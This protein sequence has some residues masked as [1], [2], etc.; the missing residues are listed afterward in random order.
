MNAG[1][2][3]FR[4]HRASDDILKGVVQNHLIPGLP[5][6]A[7]HRSTGAGHLHCQM[8]DPLAPYSW[9]HMSA[10][11]FGLSFFNHLEVLIEGMDKS[12]LVCFNEEVDQFKICL[13]NVNSNPGD[14]IS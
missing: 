4:I 10:A 12:L 9:S 1:A 7:K 13:F 8:S 11:L 3:T 5:P 2:P 6:P 14:F